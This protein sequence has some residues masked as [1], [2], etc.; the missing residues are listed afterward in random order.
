ML[1]GAEE[2]GFVVVVDDDDDEEEE[3]GAIPVVQ[4]MM[5][6]SSTPARKCDE[7]LRLLIHGVLHL[8][9]YDHEVARDARRM[10]A[11]E[12]ALWKAVA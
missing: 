8:L 9:G 1:D 7:L 4:K 12:R 3:K 2:E 11:K 10:Q 5:L 6:K